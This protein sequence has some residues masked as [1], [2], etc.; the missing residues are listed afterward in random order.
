MG[1]SNVCAFLF[2]GRVVE[3]GREENLR[4]SHIRILA[5]VYEIVFL[6]VERPCY[7]PVAFDT[8]R[9][10]EFEDSNQPVSDWVI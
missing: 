5:Y 9:P 7:F 4:L 6:A 2:P 1:V 3:T 10:K 8:D